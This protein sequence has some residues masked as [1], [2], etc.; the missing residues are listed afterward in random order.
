MAH[1]GKGG[2]E[3]AREKKKGHLP[4]KNINPCLSFALRNIETSRNIFHKGV[5]QNAFLIKSMKQS[6]HLV[7]YLVGQNLE[8]TAFC[9]SFPYPSHNHPHQQNAAQADSLLSSV[10]LMQSLFP[11]NSKGATQT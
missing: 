4:L 11:I 1:E 5:S 3:R 9:I 6:K 2:R 10:F 8:V 7:E